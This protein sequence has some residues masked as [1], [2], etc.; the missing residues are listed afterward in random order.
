MFFRENCRNVN[1]KFLNFKNKAIYFLTLLTHIKYIKRFKNKPIKFIQF[2][3][4]LKQQYGFLK[5]KKLA[6]RKRFVVRKRRMLNLDIDRYEKELKKKKML[7]KKIRP[8]CASLRD[9]LVV[10][11]S[12]SKKFKK[13]ILNLYR[14][15]GRGIN[16]NIISNHKG[17][18]NLFQYRLVDY[19]YNI[20]KKTSGVFLGY[21]FDNYRTGWLGLIK[22]VN[23]CYGYILAASSMSV[24]SCIHFENV[25]DYSL[26][27]GSRT[28]LSN[29]SKGAYIYNI[30]NKLNGKGVFAR[31]AG[32]GGLILAAQLKY[33]HISVRLPS[34][35]V[36]LLPNTIFVNVGKVSNENH[37]LEIFGKAGVGKIFN[38]RPTVRG[39]AMNAVDHHHGGRTKGGKKPKTPWGKTIKK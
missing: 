8:I 27:P 20:F 12:K 13:L 23:G 4:E 5:G 16:G 1:V 28:P 36:I 26:K 24:G 38:Y 9:K 2:I 34:R 19:N 22:Y 21:D 18:G 3:F 33:N 6:V 14:A 25:N 32:T 35:K 30:P 29:V 31:A 10:N 15:Q 17:G 7:F 37:Y 11:R 39:E